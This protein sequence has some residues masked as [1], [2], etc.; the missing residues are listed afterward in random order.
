MYNLT[1]KQKEI[2]NILTDVGTASVKELCYF[3]G[4]S[5]PVITALEQKGVI[6]EENADI[7][8]GA[9]KF[10]DVAVRDIMTPRVDVTCVSVSNS[11]DEI[12]YHK[13]SNKICIL[14]WGII[15]KY[16]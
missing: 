2:L 1:K 7:I 12:K 11:I 6:D 16:L 14:L 4:F 10:S 3:T 5:V 8:Y 9:L 13:S 15:E